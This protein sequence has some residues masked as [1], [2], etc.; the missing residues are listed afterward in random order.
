MATIC[1][2][3]PDAA[4]SCRV[5]AYKFDQVLLWGSPLRYFY[6]PIHA[7][8]LPVFSGVTELFQ[9]RSH[10]GIAGH[11]P[12]PPGGQVDA[13]HLGPIGNAGTLVLLSKEPRKEHFQ[14]L[15]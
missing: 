15:P 2:N 1:T 13:S 4:A 10:R 9:P 8:V 5:R 3:T 6:T 12:V 7:A 11:P 14:P